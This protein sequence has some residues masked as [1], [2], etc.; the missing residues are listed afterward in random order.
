MQDDFII[1][2]RNFSRSCIRL[3]LKY[4]KVCPVPRRGAKSVRLS[5]RDETKDIEAKNDAASL[6]SERKNKHQNTWQ[7]TGGRNLMGV[8][9]QKHFQ[10]FMI[11]HL[12]HTEAC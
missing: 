9:P 4:K 10:D 7:A 12:F 11:L 1:F 6:Q 8:A 5:P 2:L 3:T